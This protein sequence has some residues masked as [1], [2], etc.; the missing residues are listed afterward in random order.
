MTLTQATRTVSAKRCRSPVL[1]ALQRSGHAGQ[2]S[3]TAETDVLPRR[4]FG[5]GSRKSGSC[6]VYKACLLF[7]SSSRPF[8]SILLLLPPSALRLFPTPPSPLFPPPPP[9]PRLPAL[10]LTLFL[11]LAVLDVPECK[12]RPFRN[13]QF[14]GSQESTASGVLWRPSDVSGGQERKSGESLTA[15]QSRAEPWRQFLLGARSMNV[16][17]F[18]CFC[19]TQTA[20]SFGGPARA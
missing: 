20:R 13:S 14:W 11:V 8:L 18:L 5:R 10:L 17:T 16:A 6:C 4:I 3:E 7:G 19:G 1:H 15:A 2:P 12:R 9:A